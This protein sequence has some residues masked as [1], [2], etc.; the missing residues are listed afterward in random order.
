MENL[1]DVSY[2][3][4]LASQVSFRRRRKRGRLIRFLLLMALLGVVAWIGP[5]RIIDWMQSLMGRG[6]TPVEETDAG[7][8]VE[9]KNPIYT[10]SGKF[11]DYAALPVEVTPKAK[12]Y[13]VLTNLRNVDNQ[14]VFPLSESMRTM[15]YDSAFALANSSQE[16]FYPV[17]AANAAADLPSFVSADSALHSFYLVLDDVRRN[18]EEDWLAAE[19]R[20]L[21]KSLL[22]DSLRQY[23]A[24]RGTEWEAAARRNVAY[25]AVG[26]RLSDAGAE[27]PDCVRTEAES[28]LA[29]IG[30]GSG[31]ETS[32]VMSLGGD[33]FALD[34]ARFIPGGHYAE[35]DTLRS[36]YW[37]M[38]WFGNTA[39]HLDREQDARSALLMSYALNAK[40]DNRQSW[41][42]I[43]EP[44]NFFYGRE[45]GVTFYQLRDAMLQVY[46]SKA[47]LAAVTDSGAPW[48]SFFAEA[49]YL[50]NAPGEGFR[51]LGRGIPADVE[52]YQELTAPR[53]GN[54]G[55]ACSEAG[56]TAG[57][58]IPRALDIPAALGSVEAL[59]LLQAEGETG[60][61]C[62]AENSA[63]LRTLFAGQDD[64]VRTEDLSSG[65][66]YAMQSL[67]EDKSEGYPS[68]MVTTYWKRKSLNTYMASLTEMRRD[69]VIGASTAP[70]QPESASV[71]AA[72]KTALGYV[73]PE[74]YLYAR[75]ASLVEMTKAGLKER[76]IL[77][78]DKKES[79]DNLKALLISLK[80]ISEKELSGV[81]LTADEFAFIRG[82]GRELEKIWRDVRTDGGEPRLDGGTGTAVI[83]ETYAGDGQTL[84]EENGRV[85]EVYAVVMINKK[86]YL[87]KGAAFSHYEFIQNG[88][89]LTEA[90]WHEL[91]DTGKAQPAPWMAPL[92]AR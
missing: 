64:D 33:S 6:R 46:G 53:T 57:R 32:P 31:P 11:A 87:T 86:A 85:M 83:A 14:D 3:D 60:Y 30:A 51:L 48:G 29:L 41:D 8:A 37:A 70:A 59:G 17:Y 84:M 56:F 89:G 65:W 39:L 92:I 55:E 12:T 76:G 18:L 50:Q 47:K 23:E 67:L 24:L 21:S 16:E 26:L 20:T 22:G 15:L 45:N 79:L 90:K 38:A 5:A 58:I 52:I 81:A 66:L 44:A 4:A 75:L 77:D 2:E 73:E 80:T 9:D 25:F 91:L 27:L 40:G 43:Y 34:Y 88:G 74:P 69:T 49:A 62:Y 35:N 42:R 36:Y 7:P 68:F 72:G 10:L 71:A 82:Y 1:N 28:E 54:K 63:R 13:T 61:A 78:Q 19:L